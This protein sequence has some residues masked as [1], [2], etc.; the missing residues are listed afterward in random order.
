MKKFEIDERNEY[1]AKKGA[2]KKLIEFQKLQIEEKKKNALN[3][4]FKSNEEIFKNKKNLEQESDEFIK[5]AENWIKDY[6]NNGKN[7][8]PLLLELKKYRKHNNFD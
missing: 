7:I 6:K 2:E 3:D 5:Y 4:F 8:T 1:L